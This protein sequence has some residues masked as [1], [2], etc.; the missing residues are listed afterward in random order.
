[1]N[2]KDRQVGYSEEKKET[3]EE[4]QEKNVQVSQ[5]DIYTDTQSVGEREKKILLQ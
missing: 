5:K 1:M 3:D 2:V 4:M